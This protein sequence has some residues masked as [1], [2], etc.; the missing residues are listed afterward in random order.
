[1]DRQYYKNL[2]ATLGGA[3]GAAVRAPR[4]RFGCWDNLTPGTRRLFQTR[5]LGR[6]LGSR[7]PTMAQRLYE[8]SVPRVIRN[9][10]EN[11][12]SDYLKGKQF[13]HKMSVANAPQRAK[14]SSNIVLEKVRENVARGRRN[15]T[16]AEA[17]AAKRAGR[18]SAS[19]ILAKSALKSGAKA[20]VIAAA[21]EAPI[22]GMENYLHWRGG[23]KT[24]KQAATDTAKSTAVAGGTGAAVSV[25]LMLIP[26]GPLGAPVAIV[27]GTLLV[28][29]TIYRITMATKRNAA[30]AGRR[31]EASALWGR[32][33]RGR[34]PS[35]LRLSA[36]SSR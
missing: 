16:S 25:P 6:G 23:R 10:G 30:L 19:K 21:I 24:G 29:D 35:R 31:L 11:A 12:V 4:I 18:A 32:I 28:G 5:G 27:G 14:A 26:L 34:R 1:M 9:T 17:A 2:K 7:T 33:T 13:S 22:A 36:R 20:G 3:A 15:M 8:K